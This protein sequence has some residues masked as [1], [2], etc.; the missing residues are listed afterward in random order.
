[1]AIIS[2][3]VSFDLRLFF[4]ALLGTAFSASALAGSSNQYTMGVGDTIEVT[5]YG[6]EELTRTQQVPEN[7]RIEFQFV[8]RVEICGSTPTELSSQLVNLYADGYLVNPDVMVVV[9][10]YGS[11]TVEV[12]GEVKIPGL[13]ILKGPT[14]LSEIITMAGGPGSSSVMEAVVVSGD[15][16]KTFFLPELDKDSN[17]YWVKSGDIVVLKPPVTVNV[18][19]EVNERGPVAFHEGLT[20]TEALGLAGGPSEY[21][22]LTRVFVLRKNGEKQRVNIRKITNGIDADVRLQ[23]DDK[24]VVRRSLF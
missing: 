20:V 17:T 22:S 9:Q 1:M 12:K 13:Q 7:C 3:I 14:T 6:E 19:G 18:I 5:V 2:R 23:P 8:G 24:L 15:D 11:Q 10:E 16:A 4:T 21:A